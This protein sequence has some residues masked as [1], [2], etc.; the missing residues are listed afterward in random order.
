MNIQEL[1]DVA[2]RT[3]EQ[4]LQRIILVIKRKHPPRGYRIK[5]LGMGLGEIA[6]VQK[7]NSEFDIVAWF[8]IKDVKRYI[9][10]VLKYA[11]CPTMLRQEIENIV[12]Y[13]VISIN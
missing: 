4:G 11:T 12:I 13:V 9:E 2:K 6:N 1:E 5:V 8:D 7:N 10:R 3:E